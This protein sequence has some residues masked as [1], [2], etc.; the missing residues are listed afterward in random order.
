MHS[1]LSL[2]KSVDLPSLT[3]V[4]CIIIIITTVIKLDL[5]HSWNFFIIFMHD[6]SYIDWG[7]FGAI[8]KIQHSF[9]AEQFW[10][11]FLM[12]S[13]MQRLKAC[14]FYVLS[15]V[16]ISKNMCMVL[17]LFLLW[18]GKI[19]SAKKERTHSWSIGSEMKMVARKVCRSMFIVWCALWICCKEPKASRVWRR[20]LLGISWFFFSLQGMQHSPIMLRW[21]WGRNSTR[22]GCIPLKD[23]EGLVLKVE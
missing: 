21:K 20:A 17:L 11:N 22:A 14:N 12:H 13:L 4:R 16:T 6:R 10:C 5:K 8:M 2:R 15:S 19:D 7:W 18:V 1:Q 9:S 23:E 3:L